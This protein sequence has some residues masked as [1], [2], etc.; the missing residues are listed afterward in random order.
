MLLVCKRNQVSADA[1]GPAPRAASRLSPIVLSAVLRKCRAPTRSVELTTLAQREF[2][3][4]HHSSAGLEC[5]QHLTVVNKDVWQWLDT[6]PF[7]PVTIP[8]CLMN[9]IC[10]L[11]NE[12]N[13]PKVINQLSQ[14]LNS[15]Y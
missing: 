11:N 1:D 8:D 5:D 15:E 9:D 14:N 7:P 13:V 12:R 2:W 10:S 3:H 4:G 6:F